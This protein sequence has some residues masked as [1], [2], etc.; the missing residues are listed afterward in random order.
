[1]VL[2]AWFA[3]W[4]LSERDWRRFISEG[5]LLVAIPTVVYVSAWAVHFKLITHAGQDQMIMSTQFRMQLPGDP[6]YDPAAPKLS[7]WAKIADVHHAINYGNA[8]LEGKTHPAASPW[9]TWPIMKHPIAM[10]DRD[11]T[12]TEKA[13]HTMI[14]LL[15]NPVVWW[16]GLIGAAIGVVGFFARRQRFAGREFG[17][18]LLLGGLLLNFLPFMAIHRLMYLYHY[19]FALVWLVMFAAFSCGALATRRHAWL[20]GGFVALMLAGFVYFLP[21]T[22]GWTISAAAWDQRFWLLHPTF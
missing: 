17:F 19:L 10:W 22:Y 1:V 11:S 13:P 4:L 18:F 20:Y 14:I 7:L 12:V 9:Y 16:S 6:R 15:G 21:F 3:D 5:A 2:A 8:G